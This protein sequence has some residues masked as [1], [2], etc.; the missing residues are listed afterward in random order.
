MNQLIIIM[1]ALTIINVTFDLRITFSSHITRIL[2]S[3]NI[4]DNVSEIE[5]FCNDS[6]SCTHCNGLACFGIF[7]KTKHLEACRGDG[8]SQLKIPN[9]VKIRL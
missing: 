6:F 3:Q 2:N 4:S 1:L 9:T 8:S 7:H 5:Q